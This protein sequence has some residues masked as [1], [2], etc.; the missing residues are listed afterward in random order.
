MALPRATRLLLQ[1]SIQRANFVLQ[2]VLLDTRFPQGDFVEPTGGFSVEV[3]SEEPVFEV[4]DDEVQSVTFGS[5]APM[6]AAIE[7]LIWHEIVVAL[8]MDDSAHFEGF[9]QFDYDSER[10]IVHFKASPVISTLERPEI[11]PDETELGDAIAFCNREMRN[12]QFVEMSW[13]SAVQEPRRTDLAQYLAD[14]SC[15]KADIR[16]AQ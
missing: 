13:E 3:V 11:E 10:E 5:V 12:P 9:G 4:N 6:S 7:S 8:L 16:S 15:V 2:D 1:R 14:F